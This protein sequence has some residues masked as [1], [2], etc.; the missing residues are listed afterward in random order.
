MIV[1]SQSITKMNTTPA[2]TCAVRSGLIDATSVSS[3]DG[4][5]IH[6]P[7]TFD[8][9]TVVE[10]GVWR[11]IPGEDIASALT[12]IYTANFDAWRAR[13]AAQAT[14]DRETREKA[15]GPRTKTRQPKTY[16]HTP[17]PT[18]WAGR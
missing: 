1:Y 16:A 8:G 12:R 17:C 18:L 11:L 9:E 7:L 15:C 2:A 3:A 5:E 14:S 10:E 13:T 6:A 4:V